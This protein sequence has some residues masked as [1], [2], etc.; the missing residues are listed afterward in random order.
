[1]DKKHWPLFSCLYELSFFFLLPFFTF[2]T[3]PYRMIMPTLEMKTL[4]LLQKKIINLKH[5][6]PSMVW[7]AMQTQLSQ[8]LMDTSILIMSVWYLYRYGNSIFFLPT[9]P[10]HYVMIVVN[11]AM[12]VFCTF[13][14][15]RLIPVY[16][17]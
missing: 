3:F 4:V 2:L 7:H 12:S 5:Y 8:S 6:L 11:T 10:L 15:I 14:W 16:V 9:D 17:G 1:M 13:K